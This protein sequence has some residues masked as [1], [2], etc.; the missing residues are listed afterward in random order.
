MTADVAER[1]GRRGADGVA[2]VDVVVLD[3]PRTGAGPAVMRRLA[4]ARPRAIVYVVLRRG[5]ARP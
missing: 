1:G 5:D 4:A 2:P 3:P